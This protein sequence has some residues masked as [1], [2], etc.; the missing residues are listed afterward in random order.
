MALASISPQVNKIESNTC[1]LAADRPWS[2]E[3]TRTLPGI[4]VCSQ[5]RLPSSPYPNRSFL[6]FTTSPAPWPRLPPIQDGAETCPDRF[7]CRCR[8]CCRVVSASDQTLSIIQQLLSQITTYNNKRLG[9]YGGEDSPLD[10][11]RVRPKDKLID[12]TTRCGLIT[13]E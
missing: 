3:R 9:S 11:S 5:K 2:R 6:Y 10:I 4:R 7:R 8:R 13:I 12:E 1:C